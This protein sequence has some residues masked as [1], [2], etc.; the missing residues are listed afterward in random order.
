[1]LTSLPIPIPQPWSH[2]S[3]RSP[4][5]ETLHARSIEEDV[6]SRFDE[7]GTSIVV[8]GEHE[9]RPTDDASESVSIS[10]APKKP[11][12]IKALQNVHPMKNIEANDLRLDTVVSKKPWELV[13]YKNWEKKI[14]QIGN[15]ATI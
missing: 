1:M 7:D 5:P 14:K 10:K 2:V 3:A 6:I 12:N 15:A 13:S 4:P 11:E 8:E 9:K